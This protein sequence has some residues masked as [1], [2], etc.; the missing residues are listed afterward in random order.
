MTQIVFLKGIYTDTDMQAKQPKLIQFQW[1]SE[2][3]VGD[4]TK[5]WAKFSFM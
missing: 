5:S 3:P 2:M 1:E 4:A